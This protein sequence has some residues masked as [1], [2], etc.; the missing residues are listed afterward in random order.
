[1]IVKS[2]RT[3]VYPSFQALVVTLQHCRQPG[4]GAG[5]GDRDRAPPRSRQPPPRPRR[6]LTRGAAPCP[7]DAATRGPRLARRHTRAEVGRSEAG[8]A[9]AR[10][11][12]VGPR[13]T[14]GRVPRDL[15]DLDDEDAGV[16][17]PHLVSAEVHPASG[18][19]PL[20]DL[21]ASLDNAC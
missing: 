3:L 1:M 10:V 8:E 21:S 18:R 6:Q 4:L 17:H 2:S 19:R 11:R 5:E 14:R 9:A 12:G 20:M 7:R 13:R 15:R 16:R